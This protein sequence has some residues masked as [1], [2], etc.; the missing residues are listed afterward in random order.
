[1]S[2]RHGIDL[3]TTNS[4]MA[5]YKSGL[6]FHRNKQGEYLTPSWV[7]WRKDSQS[8]IVGEPAHSISVLS[9]ECSVFSAKRLMGRNFSDPNVQEA[10]QLLPYKVKQA[11]EGGKGVLIEVD[12]KDYEPQD[13]GAL[14]L[15][16]MKEDL[17]FLN[18]N[19]KMEH[20][21]ITVP[22]YF[23]QSQHIAT[24]EAG[25]RAGLTVLALLPEPSAAAL[26]YGIDPDKHDGRTILV[27]DLGGGTFD[28]TII[29]V[30]EDGNFITLGL[31]GDMWLGGNDF[32]QCLI[33]FIVDHIKKTHKKDPSTQASWMMEITKW[34][35]RTKTRLSDMEEV[36]I[37]E[38]LVD[39]ESGNLLVEMKFERSPKCS[40]CKVRC[41]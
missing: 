15:G 26:A 5:M 9:P 27:Y 18:P 4:V 16:K 10:I 7:T 40:R 32:D 12:D 33:S 28:V 1:M 23:N 35:E 38:V 8:W 13:I 24:M 2:D 39:R 37:Q 25:I 6:K 41:V 11:A 3:G 30:D 36:D 17:E 29:M 19:M 20:V 14:V 21:V 34:A 31:S 22:A